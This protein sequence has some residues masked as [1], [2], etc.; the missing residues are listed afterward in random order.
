MEQKLLSDFGAEGHSPQLCN[1][2]SQLTYTFSV[3]WDC[4][5]S[6]ALGELLLVNYSFN[7]FALISVAD[8]PWPDLDFY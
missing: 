2:V 3:L 4:W 6:I 5:P 8:G 7:S 1:E